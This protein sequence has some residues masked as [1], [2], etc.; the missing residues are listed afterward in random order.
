MSDN[1][2]VSPAVEALKLKEQLTEVDHKPYLGKESAVSLF[3]K[4]YPGAQ[5]AIVTTMLSVEPPVFKAEIYIDSILVATGHASPEGMTKTFRKV[6]SAA[7]RRA[8][9]NAGYGRTLVISRMIGHIG[10][11]EANKMLGS[12][13][14]RR[15]GGKPTPEKPPFKAPV[16]TPPAPKVAEPPTEQKP[17]ASELPTSVYWKPD[18]DDKRNQLIAAVGREARLFTPEQRYKTVEQMRTEPDAF[19][20]CMDMHDAVLTVAERL[21]ALPKEAANGSQ[22]HQ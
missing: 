15:L 4:D 11:D 21:E 19:N 17:A 18:T 2:N 6:E 12:G 20:G 9:E 1:P 3:K 13:G 10:L 7:I 14:E 5:S 8:L 16:S 22:S